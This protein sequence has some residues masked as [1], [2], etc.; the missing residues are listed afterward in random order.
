MAKEV[1]K[2]YSEAFKLKVVKEYEQGSSLNQLKKKYGIGGHAT[3]KRWVKKYGREGL[4]NQTEKD[5]E[6][7]QAMKTRVA[8]LEKALA[9]VVL[10]KQMLE[11]TLEVAS[12]KLE[13]DLKKNFGKKS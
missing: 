3:I 10:D 8:E 5:H 2:R 12:E 7:Y 6:E 9:Q 4:R 13:M 11:T 1:Q